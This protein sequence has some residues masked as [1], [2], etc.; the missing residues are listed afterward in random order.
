MT[1]SPQDEQARTPE[2]DDDELPGMLA[3]AQGIAEQRWPHTMDA[4]VWVAEWKK[5]LDRYPATPA[6][7]DTML[8]WFANAIMAGYD[9]ANA[10]LAAERKRIAAALDFLEPYEDVRDGSDGT[11]RPNLAMT[12]GM[13]LRGE[14][15][16]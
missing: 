6:D 4:Q 7:A 5:A 13:I 3:L 2:M 11:Q 15:P 12:V 1:P 10:R 16:Q 14:G 9:T 8:A